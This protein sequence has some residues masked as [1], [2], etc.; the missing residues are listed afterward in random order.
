MDIIYG[1]YTFPKVKCM[2][3]EEIIKKEQ[4]IYMAWSKPFCSK[5]CRND[6]NKCKTR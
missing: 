5:Y 2:Y 6:Y 3:C 1:T 4:L